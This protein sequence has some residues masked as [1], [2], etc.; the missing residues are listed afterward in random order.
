[1]TINYYG[2]SSFKIKGKNVTILTSPFDSKLLGFRFP[3][4]EADIVLIP[5]DTAEYNNVN[6]VKGTPYIIKSPGEFEIK[7]AM[8][9]SFHA[10]AKSEEGGERATIFRIEIENVNLVYLG[11]LNTKLTNEQ[12][13]QLGRV[14]VLFI[15]VGGKSTIDVKQA[16]EIVSKTEPSIVI[17]MH[18]FDSDSGELFKDLSKLD[19]FIEV[20]GSSSPDKMA[21]LKISSRNFDQ[22]ADGTRI[23]VLEKK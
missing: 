2:H 4:T 10:N 3:K 19:K 8:V 1:M 9:L 20:M 11:A 7:E 5:K 17:P 13:E 18:Y 6:A 12:L 16:A 23:I 15:P 22:T 21:N 14:D